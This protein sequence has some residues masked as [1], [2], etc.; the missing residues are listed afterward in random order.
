MI[1]ID[2]QEEINLISQPIK[3]HNQNISQN[4]FKKTLEPSEIN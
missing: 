2:Y 1:E 4:K 3:K